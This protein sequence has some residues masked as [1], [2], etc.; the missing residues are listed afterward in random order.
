[1][2]TKIVH[3]LGY[4]FVG[5]CSIPLCNKSMPQTSKSEKLRH[6]PLSCLFFFDDFERSGR[7]KQ[8]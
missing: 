6:V 7:A 1:M 5:C 8:N 3:L 4:H 2:R